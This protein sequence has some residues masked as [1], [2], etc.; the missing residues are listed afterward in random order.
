MIKIIV[1]IVTFVACFSIQAQENFR[2][3]F[4]NV[5]NLFDCYHDTLKNDEEFLSSSLRGWHEGRY[6][7]K[8]KNIAKVIVAVGEWNPPALVGLCEVENEKVMDDLVKYSPLKELGYRYVMTDSP[9]ERG[10]DVALMWQR[11][12]FKFIESR[13]IRI[14]FSDK[15]RRPT[16]DILHVT[17]KVATGDSLDVFVCHMPSRS[18]GEKESE[19]ARAYA[20]MIL[21]QY[22]DSIS[23]VR[24]HPNILIM[25]DFNDYPENISISKILGAVA[26]SGSV[27]AH[28]LYNLMAEKAEKTGTY[29][30]KG[31]WGILDHL[32]V[33]GFL[34]RHNEGMHTSPENAHIANFLFLLEDDLKYGGQKPFRTYYGMKYIGGFSDH[35]PVFLDFVVPD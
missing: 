1:F 13:S 34:L 7:Q 32:I 14:N 29:N 25:G 17:G 3:M 28:T 24:T 31:E 18:G 27:E 22:A 21:K 26:P 11:G 15:D 33:S 9:D 12:E 20:A 10:I 8:I 30:Y 5:E 4:Y 6:K 23:K 16:R 19:P 35:L 2:V